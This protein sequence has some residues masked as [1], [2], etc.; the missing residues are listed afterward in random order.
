MSG[1]TI[2]TAPRAPSTRSSCSCEKKSATTAANRSIC[3][4]STVSATSSPWNEVK[5]RAAKILRWQRGSVPRRV[6]DELVWEEPLEI[7]RDNHPICVTMRTPGNDDE[8]A[9]G[10]LVSE[11]I[12]RQRD[13]ML[14]IAPHPRNRQSN[15]IRSEER[16]VGKECRSRW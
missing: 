7:R 5:N 9:A 4:L 11:G 3:S 13:Q 12:V 2:I 16:R 8:L 1:V 6:E 15:V 14:K 10:F